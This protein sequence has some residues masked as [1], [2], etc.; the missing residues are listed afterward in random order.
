[1]PDPD[2]F[3]ALLI[4]SNDRQAMVKAILQKISK[5]VI[6]TINNQLRLLEGGRYCNVMDPLQGDRPSW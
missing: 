6:I 1:M 3:Q 4:N 2:M 5:E